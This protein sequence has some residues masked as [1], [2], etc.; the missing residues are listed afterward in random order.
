MK[1]PGVLRQKGCRKLR[2]EASPPNITIEFHYAC[3]L[4]DPCARV[5]G[6][7]KVPAV[8]EGTSEQYICTNMTDSAAYSALSGCTEGSLWNLSGSLLWLEVSPLSL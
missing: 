6:H 7:V 3:F 5:A 2:P 8:L 1:M 4:P